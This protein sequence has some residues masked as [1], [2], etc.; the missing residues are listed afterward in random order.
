[1][2]RTSTGFRFLANIAGFQCWKEVGQPRG[3]AD[4]SKYQREVFCSSKLSVLKLQPTAAVIGGRVTDHPALAN[5]EKPPSE[6]SCT[7]A[8]ILQFGLELLTE[9]R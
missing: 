9:V 8:A 5:M 3:Y 2:S 4:S 1:M 7:I 6:I